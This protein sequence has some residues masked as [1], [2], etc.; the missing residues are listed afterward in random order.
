MD[1]NFSSSTNVEC[2]TADEFD[3]TATTNNGDSYT[4]GGSETG[5]PVRINPPF[6]LT[7]LVTKSNSPQGF[8]IDAIPVGPGGSTPIGI[9]FNPDNGFVYVPNQ[10]SHTVMVI[11]GDTNTVIG[12]I[13][14][15]NFPNGVAHTA[16]TTGFCM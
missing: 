11:D 14:V 7:Y 10:D 3:I 12:N 15:G 16:P 6:P 9:E 13:A 5:T 1:C 2:P 8:V 4:F